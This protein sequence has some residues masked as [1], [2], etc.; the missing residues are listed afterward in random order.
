M[1]DM[2]FDEAIKNIKPAAFYSPRY[3]DRITPCNYNDHLPRLQEAD[4]IIEVI[5][6]KLEIKRDLFNK[7]LPFLRPDALISSNTS[8]L[9]VSDILQGMPETFARRFLITHFFN[10]PRYMH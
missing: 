9:Q 10:P 7:I 4:W 6:E 1:P 5:V 2:T 3:A 8:G